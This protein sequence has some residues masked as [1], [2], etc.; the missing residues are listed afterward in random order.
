VEY[1]VELFE[2]TAVLEVLSN[3]KDQVDVTGAPDPRIA[4]YAAFA[5]LMAP[6]LADNV[7]VRVDGKPL[8][9]K[10]AGHGHTLNDEYG[11]PL[12]HLRC[13]FIFIA[14]VQVAPDRQYTIS[15]REDNYSFPSPK[16]GQIDLAFEP[17][18]TVLL[19]DIQQ[20][21][22][23][24]K[25][26]PLTELAPGDEQKL[27]GASA[28]FQV[29]NLTPAVAGISVAGLLGQAPLLTGGPRTSAAGAS[30]APALPSAIT[31]EAPP[32]APQTGSK[33]HASDTPLLE[34]F[35][36]SGY[37]VAALLAL[38]VL[39][40]A[41]H[42]LTPG[43]GKTLMAAYLV[44][45]QGTVL[46][47]FVLGLVTT[48]THTGAVIVVAV[49]LRFVPTESVQTA[50]QG[51]QL[52]FG[53]LI[54]CIGL[55]LLLCRLSGRADH[56][57][58]GGGHHHHHHGHHH[59]HHGHGH[60]HSH[61]DHDHDE[62]GHVVPRADGKVS[63]WRLVILGMQGGIVPCWDAVVMLLVAVAAGLLWLALPML[64]AFSVGL[65]GV[66]VAVGIAVVTAKQFAQSRWGD[67]RLI[68]MLPVVSACIV[69]GLGLWL[70]YGGVHGG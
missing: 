52:I 16:R 7:T 70:C 1:R 69:I 40:G 37:S 51:I 15:V 68:R 32:P 61:A 12:K 29:P 39:F 65:A 57:H 64:L 55:W 19:H 53:L 59:H 35:S 67:S 63:V 6:L 48:L 33:L 46:H 17:G 26:K 25:K 60:D 42:A 22:D 10:V 34:L 44:G 2:S 9:L 30:P 31:V 43:H 62:H 49:A 38:A 8:T 58:L 56:V 3:F 21:S 47:A 27:R 36:S 4:M 54:V 28:R 14:A 50:L 24:L 13:D 41:A 11:N 66:L 45:E 18:A 5:K 23:S 20:P